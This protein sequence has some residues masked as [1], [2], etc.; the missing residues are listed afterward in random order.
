MGEAARHAV[1]GVAAAA[2]TATEDLLG[3]GEGGGK[4][5]A[6]AR[7]SEGA[8]GA[9]RGSGGS[10]GEGRHD[11]NASSRGLNDISA[12]VGTSP[13]GAPAGFRDDEDSASPSQRRGKGQRSDRVAP[14]T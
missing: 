3:L 12:G 1:E 9:Q 10:G 2:R 13:P 7:E 14:A 8:V 4:G 5:G 11:S 6:P